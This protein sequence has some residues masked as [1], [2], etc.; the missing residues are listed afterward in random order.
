MSKD[1]DS[2]DSVSGGGLRFRN[3]SPSTANRRSRDREPRS[4]SEKTHWERDADANTML[5]TNEASPAI[6]SNAT[7][8][9]T[10]TTS[11]ESS[12]H[13]LLD[14]STGTQQL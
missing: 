1:R 6:G 7:N 12:D 13:Y 2:N 14:D 10:T 5:I 4:T 11:G 3:Q 8:A 9:T